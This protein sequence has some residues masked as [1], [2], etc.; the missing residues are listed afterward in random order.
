MN[1][2]YCRFT[3]TKADLGDC[4]DALRRD[5]RLSDFEAKAGKDMFQEFLV[6]CQDYDI[7]DDYDDSAINELFDELQKKGE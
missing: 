4:L 3:N 5:D 7:I 2:S 1:M 6:F